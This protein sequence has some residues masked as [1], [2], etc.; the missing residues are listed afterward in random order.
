M[1]TVSIHY[2]PPLLSDLSQCTEYEAWL[3]E[4]VYEIAN[5]RLAVQELDALIY[6]P[7]GGPPTQIVSGAGNIKLGDWRPGFLEAGAPLV[8][9]TAFKLLDMLLEWVLIQKGGDFDAQVLAEDSGA[10][11]PQAPCRVSPFDRDA[12][13]AS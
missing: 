6:P 8:F 7:K 10:E 1:S 9:V 11:G 13:M 12:N 5:R 3:L 4:A 2:T